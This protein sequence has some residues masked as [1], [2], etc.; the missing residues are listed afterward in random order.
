MLRT[1]H[2]LRASKSLSTG[3]ISRTSVRYN[4]SAAGKAAGAVTGVTNAVSSV[5]S[6][7]VFWSKVA[8]ELAKQVYIKEG[9]A[10]PSQA[11]F[12]AVFDLLQAKAKAAFLNPNLIAENLKANAV[13]Y[14]VKF[15]VATVQVLGL[16]SL[17][18]IIGRRKV[19][20]YKHY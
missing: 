14:T 17:G 10:P 8:G 1:Q 13:P 6:K 15:G 19:V 5:V 7:F 2:I 20:G 3:A 9:L 11:E 18:E 12:K 16:F 4:S